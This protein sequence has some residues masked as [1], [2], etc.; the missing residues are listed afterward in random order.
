MIRGVIF[1]MDGLMFDTERLW[2]PLWAPAAEQLGLP[3][4]DEAFKVKARGLAG[5]NMLRHISAYYPGADPQKVLDLVWQLGEEVFA[6]GVPVKP[7]LRELLDYLEQIGM[8]RIVASSSP[9]SMVARNL[10]NTGT[11][12]YFHDIVCG[13][14]VKLSKP[15]PAIFLE[16]ARRLK[17]DPADCLVLED[18]YN[19]VRAGHAAGAVTVM[20]P[21][22]QPPDAEMR[23]LYNRCCQNLLEVKQLL[24]EG[25]L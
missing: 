6:K 2:T 3:A 15:D 4:P 8:P 9:R 25:A 17:L 24:A 20:V 1:D 19:G 5:E 21:D 12:R 13:T 14:D 10:Q 18:S 22:L 7:G 16:A 23:R 11:A